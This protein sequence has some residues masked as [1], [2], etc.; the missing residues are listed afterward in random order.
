LLRPR[1][2]SSTATG[3]IVEG[4]SFMNGGALLGPD[5]FPVAEML[6]VQ[7]HE[8]GHYQNLAHTEVNGQIPVGD[9]TGPS[10]ANTFPVESLV[11][12]IETM[13]PFL[14]ING[15]MATPHRDDIAF[16]STLYPEPHFA[17][18]RAMRSPSRSAACRSSRS[19][20]P[21]PSRSRCLPAAAMATAAAIAFASPTER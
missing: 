7:V 9:H 20:A 14:Y 5:A 18:T 3:D 1:F 19:A 4:V 21:T 13:Y 10:P 11:G 2:D 6:S 12:R 16:F 17:S 15:G 8:F